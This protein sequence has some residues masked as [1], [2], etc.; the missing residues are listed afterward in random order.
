MERNLKYG[1]IT[2]AVIAAI[3]AVA[4]FLYYEK[5][6]LPQQALVSE[7]RN[8]YMTFN[9][10]D[11]TSSIDTLRA[12]IPDAPTKTEQGRLQV[13][14]ASALFG[15]NQDN[16]LTE[17]ISILK[18]VIND[19]SIA[20]WVRA[21]ALNNIATIVVT[22]N[23]TFYTHNFSDQS[24]ASYLPNSGSDTERIRAVY[25]AILKSSDETYPTSFAEFSIAG[26]YLVPLIANSSLPASE[27]AKIAQDMQQYVIEGDSREDGVLYSTNTVLYGLLYR[28]LAIT[29]SG[30][31]LNNKTLEEREQAYRRVFDVAEYQAQTRSAS[32]DS[33]LSKSALLWTGFWYA[34]FLR[35]NYTD[36]LT[37]IRA[38]LAPF[39]QDAA[40]NPY[41][42]SLGKLKNLPDTVYLKQ[43]AV[44]LGK[45]SPEFKAFLSSTGVEIK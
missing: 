34:N 39:A 37:D 19:Y 40:S 1:L 17:S 9:T 31:I 21:L 32:T 10:G 16:D 5:I 20:P 28:A 29:S 12:L 41:I 38:L 43:Q 11:F 42:G 30:R 8:A 3:G 22:H 36:R 14:L 35:L 13:V 4:G 15:R 44:A 7:A 27:T 45:I 26:N 6:Y 18:N 33:L 24:F 2:A 25:Y 23:V